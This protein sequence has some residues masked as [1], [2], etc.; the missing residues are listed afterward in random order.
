MS[1]GLTKKI[2]KNK[3]KNKIL[4]YTVVIFNKNKCKNSYF[5]DN[6]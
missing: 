4:T 1:F 2:Q 5:Y 6:L 3:R